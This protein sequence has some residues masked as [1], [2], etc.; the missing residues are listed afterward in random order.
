MSWKY[1]L[2]KKK[3]KANKIYPATNWYEV[4]ESYGKHCYT[5]TPLVLSGE[6]PK[7]IIQMLE[8]MLSDIKDPKIIKIKKDK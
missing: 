1:A 3:L 8:Q 6:S 5:S 2:K 7:E 4:C